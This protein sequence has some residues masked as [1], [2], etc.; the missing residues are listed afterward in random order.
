MI[1]TSVV[2]KVMKLIRLA[3]SS[4]EEEARSAAYRAA[5][6][7]REFNLDVVDPTAAPLTSEWKIILSRYWGQCI[8]CRQRY[9]VG[10]RIWWKKNV[11]CRCMRCHP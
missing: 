9:K 6:L 2:D 3:S 5:S 10:E 4:H 1:R 8:A 11:G 7:I